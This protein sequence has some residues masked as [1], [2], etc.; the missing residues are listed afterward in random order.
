[1]RFLRFSD[2]GSCPCVMSLKYFNLKNRVIVLLCRAAEYKNG[3]KA[4]ADSSV[5]SGVRD[6]SGGRCASC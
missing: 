3:I 6:N 1:M 5:P 4:H 2:L